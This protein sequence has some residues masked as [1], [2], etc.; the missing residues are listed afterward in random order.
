MRKTILQ[1][2]KFY[3]ADVNFAVQLSSL[4]GTLLLHLYTKCVF[5]YFGFIHVSQY[6]FCHMI[7]VLMVNYSPC[8]A[9]FALLQSLHFCSSANS[10]CSTNAIFSCFNKY[11]VPRKVAPKIF[12]KSCTWFHDL[13]NQLSETSKPLET[14]YYFANAD[15]KYCQY[16]DFV[17]GNYASCCSLYLNQ[18]INE[19]HMCA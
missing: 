1:P 4:M 11:S 6:L 12:P 17:F 16:I 19:I 14:E 10:K 13:F 3:M 7:H 9:L 15:G 5:K 8:F 2:Y 18:D